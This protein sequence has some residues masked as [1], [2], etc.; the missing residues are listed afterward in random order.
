MLQREVFF[1][2]LEAVGATSGEGFLVYCL[3]GFQR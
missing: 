3:L 1:G 2:Y